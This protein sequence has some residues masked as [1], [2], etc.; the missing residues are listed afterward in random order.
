MRTFLGTRQTGLS[1]ALLCTV[2]NADVSIAQTNVSPPQGYIG[3]QRA[4]DGPLPEYRNGTQRGHY[5]FHY[6]FRLDNTSSELAGTFWS[7]SIRFHNSTADLPS[8]HVGGSQGGYLGVQVLNET[9]SIAIFS[10]WWALDA[11]PGPG[12]HCVDQIEAWY[13]DD[14]PFDPP[15]HT[16]DEVDASRPLAGGPFRSCRLPIE[17]VAGDTYQ[18]RVVE[19]SDANEPDAPEWW[20]ATLYNVSKDEEQ[21]I[22]QLQV[23]GSWGWLEGHAGGF[24]EH[25]GPMPNG[26][27]SIPASSSMFVATT[28]DDGSF[29]SSISA[30]V[31]GQCEPSISARSTIECE[32]D[33]CA[34]E[35][36]RAGSPS[37]PEFQ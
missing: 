14:R 24:I 3:F 16:M 13:N 33:R 10:I 11:R 20:G 29:T 6:E 23:P 2:L 9:E 8:N 35:V 18:L 28:A 37:P 7:N 5:A 22:G 1:I 15:V 32:G 4:F 26:C 36:R 27:D 34:V 21:W 17:L 30:R 19:V 25:F 31:Y 12:A